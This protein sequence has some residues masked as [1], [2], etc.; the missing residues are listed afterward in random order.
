MFTFNMVFSIVL[1]SVESVSRLI[2]VF[3]RMITNDLCVPIK[4]HT[5]VRQVVSKFAIEYSI[6]NFKSLYSGDCLARTK[7][8]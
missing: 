1:E 7:H 5:T 8:N 3:L 4:P 2:N 6:S